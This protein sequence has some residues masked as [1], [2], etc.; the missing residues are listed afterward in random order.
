[1]F[2]KLIRYCYNLYHTWQWTKP[3]C[4]WLQCHEFHLAYCIHTVI[5]TLYTYHTQ[6]CYCVN[7]PVL[8]T[9]LGIE[10]QVIKEH[11]NLTEQE[12]CTVG[13]YECIVS[14]KHTACST[15]RL[16]YEYI[17]SNNNCWDRPICAINLICTRLYMSNAWHLNIV[18]LGY[19]I[20]SCIGIIG[21]YTWKPQP[22]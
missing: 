4:R 22:T 12:M 15:N 11:S 10:W 21:M 20:N 13:T 1:M 14:E 9:N 5:H 7:Q 18:K 2:P 17:S 19:E 8:G 3:L 16:M 6:I